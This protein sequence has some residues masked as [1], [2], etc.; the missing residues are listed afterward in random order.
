MTAEWILDQTDTEK[1]PFLLTIQEQGRILQQFLVQDSWPAE[2]K[3]IFCLRPERH[4]QPWRCV[5]QRERVPI[6][7][8]QWRGK[9]LAVVLDR[10]LRK[11]CEFLFTEKRYKKGQGS[12]EQIFWRTQD[13]FRQRPARIKSSSG[14]VQ[15]IEILI[16]SQERYPY[17]F[18]CSRRERLPVG[19]Y[20]VQDDQGN[21]LALIERKTFR[22]FLH[23]LNRINHLHMN[24]AE[25]ASYPGAALVVEA[26]Y[27]YFLDPAKLRP[28]QIKPA[29][30][31]SL[32]MELF[33]NHRQVHL[34]FMENRKIAQH[35]CESFLKACSMTGDP[36]QDKQ[37]TAA[38]DK[39]QYNVPEYEHPEELIL[40]LSNFTFAQLRNNFPGWS[41]GQLRN[42]LVKFKH[43]GLIDSQGR[44]TKAYWYKKG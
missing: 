3:N 20:G 36:L 35:W 4:T 27:H 39:P 1:F 14:K 44:G 42:I 34:V 19:D 40:A 13:Y 43:K 25:L 32:I 16:D 38:E 11:R 31:D 21:F 23:S 33:S 41:Q 17:N 26:P 22:D 28:H 18:D 29:I 8:L 10:S 15:Q 30:A 12:Y 5:A 2:G 9:L 6:K 37:S 7:A 24:L